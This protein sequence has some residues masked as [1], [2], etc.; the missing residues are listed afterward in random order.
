M[1]WSKFDNQISYVDRSMFVDREEIVGIFNREYAE[2]MEYRD[3][4]KVIGIYGIGGIGKSRLMEQL[5]DSINKSDIK[6]HVI[7]INMEIMHSAEIFE[8]LVKVRK[9]ITSKCYYFDYAL[10][11]LWDIYKIEKIDDDFMHV[12]K[13]NFLDVLNM[14]DSMHPDFIISPGFGNVLSLVRKEI[15]P[16]IQKFCLD[17]DVIQEIEERFKRNPDSLYEYMPHLLG[18]DLGRIAEEK[19]LIAFFDS[20]ERYLVDHDDWLKE[21]IGSAG[22]GM[23]IIASREKLDWDVGEELLVTY[24]LQELPASHASL[25]LKSK[26][27][28]EHYSIID[29]VLEKTQCVPIYIELAVN[30]YKSLLNKDDNNIKKEFWL[31]QN[32]QDFVKKFL[33]HLPEDDKEIVLL[34]SVVRVF[35]N[36]IFEWIV[37]DL[38]LQCNILKFHD[39]CKLCLVNLLQ[40]DDKFYKLHDVFTSNAV[41]FLEAEKKN[42]I[43]KSY[44]KYIGTRGLVELTARQLSVLFRNL[45]LIAET[46]EFD[47]EDIELLCDIFFELYENKC[48]PELFSW[49]ESA[50]A[51][52]LSVFK[53]LVTVLFVEKKSAGESY[54][55]SLTVSEPEKLGRHEKSFC[56][57]QNYARAIIGRY[58]EAEVINKK[59]YLQLQLTDH[60]YWYYGKTKIYYADHLMLQGKFLQALSIFREYGNEL[61]YSI[62]KGDYFEVQKQS[63]HCYR[64]N[65]CLEKAHDIY[66]GLERDY[67]H[68][69]SLLVY[70]LANLCETNCYFNPDYVFSI[71]DEAIKLCEQ[72][73][74]PKDLAKIYYSLAIACLHRHDYETSESYIQKSILLNQKAQY[75]SGV[76]FAMMAKAYLEYALAD[77]VSCDTVNRIREILS[78]VQ[79]YQYFELPLTLLLHDTQKIADLET[80]FEWVD[81]SF[82]LQQYKR[83]FTLISG[84]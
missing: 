59:L 33:H 48:A 58:E 13:G 14:L 8:N 52:S 30:I 70:I 54:E 83:F 17:S 23:F 9:Q 42:R 12:I 71:Q 53:Q 63:G 11:M 67:S 20:Y 61:E 21:L 46:I 7:M 26:L 18:I 35:N 69:Q 76:L 82:T 32:K 4:F 78:Q 37:K 34:L 2:F 56:L 62:N 28:P 55:Y 68:Y 79:V 16:I 40:E 25:I 74:R 31:I 73:G 72:T 57:I 24:H 39:L 27:N 22:I 60:H 6:S 45:M 65:F 50:K 36:T 64:F 66:A 19:H 15:V 51:P 84:H 38:H 47:T 29:S 49:V 77:E 1:G 43:L 80:Q 10:L 81:F 75:P 41:L 44:L 3:Y 5:L